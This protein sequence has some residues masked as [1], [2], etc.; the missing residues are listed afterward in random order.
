MSQCPVRS[1]TRLWFRMD[2]TVRSVSVT[3]LRWRSALT[4]ILPF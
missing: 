2:A 3:W 1:A 4:P